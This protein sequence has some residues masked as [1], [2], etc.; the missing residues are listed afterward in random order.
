[1]P[2]VYVANLNGFLR[3]VQNYVPCHATQMEPLLTSKSF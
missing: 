2:Q 3:G 1:M